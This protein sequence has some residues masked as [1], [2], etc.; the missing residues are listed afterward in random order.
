MEGKAR[1]GRRQGKDKGNEKIKAWRNVKSKGT[2][3]GKAKGM[4]K[5]KVWHG[6]AKSKVRPKERPK[7]RKN[8]GMAKFKAKK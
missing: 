4:Q 3:K 5:I 2:V 8:K 7:E 6:T 1:H